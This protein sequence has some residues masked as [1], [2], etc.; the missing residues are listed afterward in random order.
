MRYL[1][2]DTNIYLE[3]YRFA[4][5]DLEELRKLSELVRTRE[6]MLY[7][8]EQL[9]DEFRRN[10]ENVLA[11]AMKAVKDT[12]VPSAFPQVLRNYQQF[13]QL[14]RARESF[15]TEVNRL[16]E[17]AREDAAERRLPADE[18]LDEL[19]SL[20]VDHQITDAIVQ[21]AKDRFD[22]GNPP[23]KDKSYG[24]A[25]TW[26]ALLVHH[27][28]LF[29]LDIIT[30]DGDYLSPLR[31]DALHE[32]LEHEWTAKKKST[33]TAYETLGSYLKEHYPDIELSTE[34]AS[35][36]AVSRLEGSGSFGATHKA[37]TALERVGDFT[38]DQVQRLIDAALNNGQVSAIIGDHDVRGFF[39]RLL[40]W[41]GAAAGPD[42]VAALQ[43]LLL[44]AEE[45][46]VST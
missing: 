24:D 29:H 40:E 2:I 41:H 3:F 34:V 12:H 45:P 37:I 16:L 23:G 33:V 28:D 20:A 35:T 42:R 7:A 22:R 6:I 15:A 27:P 26:E 30:A 38:S 17:R 5:D 13:Q 39:Q 14:A 11:Q 46:E 19:M 10:R 18:L 21:S 32:Y 1:L 9:R 4:K 8:N 44:S 25:I 43:A 36:V 31:S